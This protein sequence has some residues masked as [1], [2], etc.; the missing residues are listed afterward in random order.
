M[1]DL[2]KSVW[3]NIHFGKVVAWYGVNRMTIHFSKVSISP[4]RL[5]SNIPVLH[6]ILVENS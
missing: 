4:S 3:E 1:D 6:F 5:Y 2:K